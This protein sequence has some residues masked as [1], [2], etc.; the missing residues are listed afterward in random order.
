[1][2]NYQALR[3]EL[4]NRISNGLSIKTA[5]NPEALQA[6]I[7]NEV[8]LRLLGQHVDLRSRK[9]LMQELYNSL[10]GLDILQDLLENDEIT[11]IMVNGPEHIFIERFGQLEKSELAF[12]HREHL[13]HVI[14]HFSSFASPNLNLSHPIGDLRLSDG[15]RA[16]A[17]LPPLAPDGPILTIRK[18]SGIKPDKEALIESRFISRFAMNFLEEAVQRRESIFI[19]GGTGSGKTT[20]LNVLSSFIP[21]S[22]RV[23]TIEDSAELQLQGLPNLVRLESRM[24][25]PESEEIDI[26]RLIRTAM[27]MRPDRIIVGEVRGSEAFDMLTAMNSG[28]PGTLC[29]GHAN[30][31]A[32]MMRRLCNMILSCSKLPYD[33]IRENLASSIRYLVHLSRLPDGRRQV[34]EMALVVEGEAGNYHLEPIALE[35]GEDVVED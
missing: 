31:C 7:A 2:D 12:D 30:S 10:H 15:S 34:D 32:D 4:R 22:E 3:E 35:A 5:Q 27:R 19:C 29:T 28:H 9:R 1:M 24:A 13:T 21:A 18:F 25:G 8:N 17:V 26:G 33:A 14:T 20:L 11:E 23:I 6:L 16:N